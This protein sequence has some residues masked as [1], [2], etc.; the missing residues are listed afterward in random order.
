M[1][2]GHTINSDTMGEHCLT[3]AYTVYLINNAKKKKKDHCDKKMVF[4]LPFRK[5]PSIKIA[6]FL[7]HAKQCNHCILINVF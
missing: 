2:L 7:N 1:E 3:K 4:I 6:E 5:S